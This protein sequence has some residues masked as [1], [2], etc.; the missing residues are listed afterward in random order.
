MRIIFY[1]SA[2]VFAISAG[3]FLAS[4]FVTISARRGKK[5]TQ[6]GTATLIQVTE[7]NKR[8]AAQWFEIEY[9]CEG[10]SHKTY[11][12]G[13]STETPAGTQVPIWYDP[14]DPEQVII[15][16]DPSMTKTVKSWKRTRKRC[17]IWTLISVGIMVLAASLGEKTA[18][19]PLT[20][21]TIGQFSQEISALADKTPTALVYTESIGSPGTFSAMV[22]DPAIAKEALDIIL[23]ASVDRRGWQ[24]DMYQL[25]DADYCFVFGEETYTFGFVPNS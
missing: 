4:F 21:T 3:F 7:A 16:E 19:L 23:S 12:E 9:T 20:T 11:A 1:I 18:D 22:D 6:K 15:A 5:C 2:F 25:Q 17:L 8:D 14:D 10:I 24:M 13:V